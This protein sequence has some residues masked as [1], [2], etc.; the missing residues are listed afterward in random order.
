M[1]LVPTFCFRLMYKQNLELVK[2]LE[3]VVTAMGYEMWGIEHFP[4]GK[5]TL[6]RI[7]IDH[8][9]GITLADCQRVSE[10]LIGVLDVNDPIQGS[11]E[12]EISSPGLDRQ[13]FTLEQFEQFKG[14]QV[15]LRLR[16]K[17]DG[18][19]KINGMIKAVCDEV[20]Y[21]VEGDE[22]YNIAADNIEKA[23]IKQ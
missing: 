3:P 17:F 14:Y 20:V 15:R 4:K 6:L 10:Q 8:E 5:A 22:T 18:R 2:L 11:Y 1:G 21:I 7:Y 12:L 13:L 23:N 9:V 19:R 16:T